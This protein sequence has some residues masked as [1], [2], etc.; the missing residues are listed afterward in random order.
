MDALQNFDKI[1]N[2]VEERTVV[3]NMIDVGEY[4]DIA[5]QS[6]CMKKKKLMICG[7]TFCQQLNCDIFRPG[8]GCVVCSGAP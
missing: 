3:F 1:V 7:G 5:M 6:L 8:E 2:F 4:W